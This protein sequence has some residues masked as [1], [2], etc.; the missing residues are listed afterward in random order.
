[1]ASLG[2]ANVITL[3]IGLAQELSPPN[4]RARIVSTFMMIMF[5]L[6]PIASYLV[7]K[8]ADLVGISKMMLV[9]GTI[10]VLA[11]TILLTVPALHRLKTIIKT[12]PIGHPLKT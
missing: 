4:M 5:G 6:Q 11:S 10:M 9:N 3:S 1:M 12:P 2:A 8:G 7:G